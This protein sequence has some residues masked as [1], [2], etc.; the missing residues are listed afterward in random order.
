MA[1]NAERLRCAAET[2]GVPIEGDEYIVA[3]ARRLRDFHQG[4]VA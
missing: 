1:R 2:S 4:G 3:V